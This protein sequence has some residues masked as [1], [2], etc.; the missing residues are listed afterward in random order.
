MKY[1]PRECR[2]PRFSF[3][4]RLA[5]L[6]T[7]LI[8]AIDPANAG[9]T[10][11][12][13]EQGFVT[14]SYSL[15][16]HSE[17]SSFSSATDSGRKFD[18][19]FRRNRITL[20]GQY[21]DYVGFYAQLE[22]GND[23]KYARDD[24]EVFYRDAYVT[25]DLSDPLR[26]IAGRF[27]NTFSRENLEACLE[28]L[29]LDR[30][31]IAYTPFG[32]TRDTGAAIWGNLADAK[33]Q[34]RLMVSDGREGDEVPEDAPRLTARV[35]LSLLEPEYS[36]GYLG[37]YLGT[38]KVLTVGASFDYQA[39]VAYANYPQREDSED[40]Q[41]WTAD[42]FAE[43]PTS[44]GTL[45]G[46][47]AYFDYSLGDVFFASPDP[48]LPINSELEAYYVKG[49]YLFPSPLGIGRLQLYARYEDR[50]YK[51]PDDLFDNHLYSVGANYY[52]DGQQLKL[53]F[54]YT[55]TDFATEDPANHALQDQ[56]LATFGLQL[57]F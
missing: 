54:E 8:V 45:T 6:S 40:Y 7:V 14:L 19:F 56:Q 9:P 31:L 39:N 35:H 11:E 22:A 49:G 34:Y 27:K 18:T 3:S 48:A 32:G 26:F 17:Y 44:F 57:I 28:P 43:Y 10:I 15:Q 25:L 29:T 53:T 13:G 24:K 36:Y 5:A 52:I 37:T 20:T 21:N 16:I 38:Q 2:A 12:F 23:S 50:D 1:P 42:I 46:S 41:A 51:F 30:S 47:A 33:I 4:W 55:D